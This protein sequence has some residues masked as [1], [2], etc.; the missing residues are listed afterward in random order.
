MC[1]S[2]FA[3]LWQIT[4]YSIYLYD[5][6]KRLLLKCCL[7]LVSIYSTAQTDINQLQQTAKTF[8]R[9]G[10]YANAILVLNR[11]IQQ[12]PNNM[13]LSKDLALSYYFT[14][15]NDKAL[16]TIKPLLEKDDV[17]DQCFQIA[18]NIYKELDLLKDCEKLYKKGIK[19]F[20]QSG[21]L[22]ND[23]GELLWAQRNNDA[24]K[25][26]EKGIEQDPSYPRNYYSAARFYYLTTDKIWS[27]LYGETFINM[28]PLGKNTIEIKDILLESYKKLFMNTNLEQDTKD[29]NDFEKAFLQSMNKQSS[30]ATLGIN[31][32]TLTMI[33]TRFILEWNNSN[34]ARF[35]F[36]L[37]DYQQQL[38]QEGMFDAYDQWIFGSSENL[39]AYQNW[40]QVHKEEYIAFTNFQR[41]RAYKVPAGQH[42]K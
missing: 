21:A 7:L 30:L 9:Q 6:M 42:Y 23:Y 32:E 35:P 27:I 17:D 3:P 10:D 28:E 8:M 40:T 11:G 18:G 16:A 2:T 19:K 4:N 25:Q 5:I 20:P 34:K 38:I 14:K 1:L 24:I 13:A 12:D 26:W 29:M 31:T 39:P 33:R 41:G 36:K 15:E 22:Y 37:F